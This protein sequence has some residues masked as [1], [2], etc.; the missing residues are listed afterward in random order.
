VVSYIAELLYRVSPLIYKQTHA[1]LTT[2]ILRVILRSAS[3][4]WLDT[5]D[6]YSDAHVEILLL[7]I[8]H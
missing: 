7:D 2:W 6:C 3:S 5:S 8:H 4:K 1:M